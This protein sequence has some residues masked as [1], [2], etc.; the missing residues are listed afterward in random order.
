MCAIYDIIS[1]TDCELNARVKMNGKL[2]SDAI[3]SPIIIMTYDC[4]FNGTQII[5]LQIVGICRVF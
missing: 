4:I 3:L 2:Y 5:Y 1:G